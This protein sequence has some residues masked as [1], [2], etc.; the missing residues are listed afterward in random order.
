MQIKDH[1]GT[2][3]TMSETPRAKSAS[4]A[5]AAEPKIVAA[6]AD[7]SADCSVDTAKSDNASVTAEIGGP[8]GL[9]PTRYGDW[10]RK[11][12]CIDF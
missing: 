7:L 3:R 12:R 6:A 11:G 9:E 10:E 2:L 5:R 8:E 1:S 4:R